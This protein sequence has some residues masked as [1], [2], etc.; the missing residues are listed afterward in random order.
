[1]GYPS[2]KNRFLLSGFIRG[3]GTVLAP[4]LILLIVGFSRPS[5]EVRFLSR[6]LVMAVAWSPQGKYLALSAGDKVK[7]LEVQSLREVASAEV[8]A[9]SHSLVFSP[10]GTLLAAGSRDGRIRLWDLNMGSL[11]VT[12]RLV[13]QAHKKGVNSLVF[14]PDGR[15]LASGGNDAVART[16]D[17]ASGSIQKEIIGGTFAVPSIALNPNGEILAVVNGP[18]IRLREVIS[19][20]ITGT[21]RADESLFSLAYSPD[22]SILAAGTTQNAVL[23]WDPAQAF[24]TGLEKYPVPL[25]LIGHAGQAGNYRSLVWRLAFSPDGRWLASAGGDATIRLW[26]ISTGKLLVTLEGHHAAVTSLA[27]SPDGNRLASGSLDASLRIWN[28]PEISR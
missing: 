13:I 18:L 5:V 15:S 28:L 20:R 7:L 27:F 25:R 22:G 6:E 12:P 17:V 21:L 9:L 16:W 4:L 1:V 26:D 11:E 10:D 3:K 14:S 24:R 8:G 23:I 19:G 2:L